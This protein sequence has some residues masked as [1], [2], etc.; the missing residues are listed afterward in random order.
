M[1]LRFALAG[2][3]AFMT[4]AAMTATA[5]S[6]APCP[7]TRPYNG[8]YTGTYNNRIAFPIGGLGT[9]MYCLEGTGF[10]SHMSVRH[11]PDIFFEPGMFAAIHVKDCANGAK[12]LEGPVAQWRKFGAPLS[13]LGGPRHANYGLPRFQ[14]SSFEARFPFG[15][16]TLTDSDIPLSVNITG[17]NPFIPGDADN[18]SLPVGILEYTF[19]NKS[20]KPLEAVFSF[21]SR[22]FMRK[23][24]GKNSIKAMP[25]GFILSQEGTENAPYQQG[26][27]AAYTDQEASVDH[28]W[29]RGGWY[30]GLTMVWNTIAAGGS[31]QNAPV[32]KDAPGASLY[33]PLSLQAGQKKTVKIFTAWYVSYS[34][35]RIGNDPIDTQDNNVPQERLNQELD[36]K[37]N[38]RPWYSSK[39]KNVRAVADYL[40]RHYDELR[41]QSE[42]F[43]RTFYNT[44]LPAEVVEAV[45]ANLTILKSPTVLRTHDG[46][47]WN[48]EGCRDTH[49]SCPGSCTHVWNYAQAIAHLFPA[50]ERTLRQTEFE[51]NQNKAGHQSFRASLPIRPVVHDFY[52]AADGQ[53]GGIMKVYR[54]WRISGDGAFVKDMYPKVKASLDYCTATWD[55]R[56]AGLI[57]EPHHNTY[58]IE[59]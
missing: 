26:D 5:D 53:L 31:I 39:F 58:D 10:I 11:A 30:D 7:D 51:E 47:L 41:A 45:A 4:A 21:H 19:E 16:V 27:F 36:Y 8:V 43:T 18:S 56:H 40:T 42:L 29:F 3:L 32:D 46:R 22:N 59:F 54:D 20:E 15:K 1:K 57:E 17:W 38:Y 24:D 12:I 13:A 44:T 37:G 2:A 9:G 23:G 33:V 6:A 52:A 35:L 14:Q 48:W 49:G 50:L 25:N 55:P 34:H 28:C